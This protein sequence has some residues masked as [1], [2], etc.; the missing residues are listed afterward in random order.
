MKGDKLPEPHAWT[1][2]EC[3]WAARVAHAV[4]ELSCAVLRCSPSLPRTA[5]DGIY[6][7]ARHANRLKRSHVP[8]LLAFHAGRVALAGEEASR[9]NAALVAPVAALRTAIRSMPT[10]TGDE[11]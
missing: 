11:G 2:L 10:K 8:G 3:D 5:I 7:A 9:H 6:E 4:D 1:E